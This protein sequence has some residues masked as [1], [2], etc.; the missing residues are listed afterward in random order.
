MRKLTIAAGEFKTRCLQLMDDVQETHKEIVITKYS[1]PVA[2]LVPADDEV[3]DSFGHMK[4]TV[5]YHG[6]IVGPDHKSWDE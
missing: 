2:K 4:G 1:K 3:P 6:D 5:I